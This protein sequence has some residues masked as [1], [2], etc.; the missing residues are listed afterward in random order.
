[1][2]VWLNGAF[3]AG[4][5]TTVRELQQLIPGSHVFDPE[6]IG[7]LLRDRLLPPEP[8]VGLTDYQDL[9]SWRRLV[10]DALTALRAQVGEDAPLLVPM[11]LHRQDYRD[12]IFGTLASRRIDVHHVV[13]HLDETVLRERIDADATEAD[14]RAWRLR[15]LDAYTTALPWLRRDAALVDTAELTPRQAAERVLAVVRAGTARVPIVQDPVATGDTVA[16]AVLLF[17]EADRVLLVDPVYKPG[18]EFP[19]GVVETGESPSAAAVREA[20]E[21]LGLTLRAEDLRL[22][23]TDWEPRRGPR[24]GGLRLVFDAGVLAATEQAGLT[25]PTAELRAWRFVAPADFDTHLAPNK[26]ARLRAA[27]AARAAGTVAYLEAG[28]RC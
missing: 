11:A 16:A 20:A 15:H 25:L 4:K 18:W 8:L 23:V 6:Q 19:G 2:I 3:G 14:A 22:L 7:S 5:T 24:S 21:E 17:D 26:A 13:L 1:M 27:L 12:E 28:R 10:P 9:V